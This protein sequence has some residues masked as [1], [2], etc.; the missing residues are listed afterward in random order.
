MLACAAMNCILCGGPSQFLFRDEKDPRAY[1]HCGACDLRFLDPQF[2]LAAHDEGARYRTHQNDPRDPRYRQFL[3]PLTDLIEAS[4]ATD[5]LDFGC[6]DGKV[7]DFVL[8]PKGIRVANYD[9]FFVDQPSV[10][11][12]TYDFVAASEVIE[13]VYSPD[14]V[15]PRLRSLLRDGGRLGLMTELWRSELNFETWYYRRDPTHVAFYSGETCEWIREKFQFK[16]LRIHST[17]L[18]EFG[19]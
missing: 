14:T 19:T 8:S 5:V 12:R 7:V 9:P 18:V 17:R 13:H 10:L 15:F 4:G 1:H 11:S 6:G 3:R 2:R 16:F